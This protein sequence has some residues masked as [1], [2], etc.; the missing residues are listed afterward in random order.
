MP[1]TLNFVQEP[2]SKILVTDTAGEYGM[3]FWD[4]L[5]GGAGSGFATNSRGFIPHSDRWNCLF[6]D[7]HVKTLTPVQTASPINMWG[8]FKTN[9]ASDGPNCDTQTVM[10]INCDAAPADGSLQKN[11]AALTQISQ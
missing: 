1:V 2:S 7:G 11:L 9:Q 6:I 5:G 8:G 10:N 4:W 3:A